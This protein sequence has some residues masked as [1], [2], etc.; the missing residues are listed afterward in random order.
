MASNVSHILMLYFIWNVVRQAIFKIIRK[1]LKAQQHSK[2]LSPIWQYIHIADIKQCI[3]N[4]VLNAVCHFTDHPQVTKKRKPSLAESV[5]STR[6]QTPHLPWIIDRV[7]TLARKTKETK[8][9]WQWTWKCYTHTNESLS[10]VCSSSHSRIKVLIVKAIMCLRGTWKAGENGKKI[11]PSYFSLLSFCKERRRKLIVFKRCWLESCWHAY[12]MCV[13][14]CWWEKVV[15]NAECES[16]K[17]RK[18]SDCLSLFSY[19]HAL[20]V[21]VRRAET[22]NFRLLSSSLLLTLSD[23]RFIVLKIAVLCRLPSLL[24]KAVSL[25]F[26]TR[27]LSQ[28]TGLLTQRYKY[29]RVLK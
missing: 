14:V 6:L 20:L 17:G 15:S 29:R 25:F 16:A 3:I 5:K 1:E 23:R 11:N 9:T 24:I 26:H 27:Q 7:N 12:S 28:V 18:L 10:I 4:T 2:S 22:N 21:T 19:P 13:S 8:Q